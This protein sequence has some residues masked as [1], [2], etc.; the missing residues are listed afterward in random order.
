MKV[1]NSEKI[2]SKNMNCKPKRRYPECNIELAVNGRSVPLNPFV[3][4]IMSN[5][6]TGMVKSLTIEG[7][8]KKI[9]L[10]LSK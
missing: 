8:I 3:R 2:R 5:T 7:P 10:K 6:V 1:T 9:C 4:A